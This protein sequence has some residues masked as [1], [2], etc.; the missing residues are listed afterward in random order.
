M[1][2]PYLRQRCIDVAQD[3]GEIIGALDVGGSLIRGWAATPLPRL[4]PVVERIA[5]AVVL[6]RCARADLP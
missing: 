5:G 1:D 6:S 4:N 2:A 3:P